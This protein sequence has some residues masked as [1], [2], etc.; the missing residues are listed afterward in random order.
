MVKE[1]TTKIQK[2]DS[3][4]TIYL[5]KEL[6]NDSSFPFIPGEPLIV[7]IDGKRLVVEKSNK[8]GDRT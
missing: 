7:R 8:E 3:R 2:A 6:V 4:H 5:K 1:T